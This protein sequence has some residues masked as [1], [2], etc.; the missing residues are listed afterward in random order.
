MALGIGRTND[1]D[2]PFVS[3]TDKEFKSVKVSTFKP[4]N[5][6]LVAEQRRRCLENGDKPNSFN[7]QAK[8]K[9]LWD[10]L[11]QNPA[12]NPT[13]V[14]FFQERDQDSCS[15]SSCHGT[16]QKEEHG[17]VSRRRQSSPDELLTIASFTLLSA[18]Q[19]TRRRLWTVFV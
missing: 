15:K 4:S 10:Y 7:A 8:R 5:G 19:Q 13:D 16:K 14:V 11:L 2:S 9:A 3:F 6:H 17:L 1:D 12:V 18:S